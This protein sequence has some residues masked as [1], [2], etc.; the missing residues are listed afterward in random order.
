MK[1]PLALILALGFTLAA[2]QN[3][4]ALQELLL[5][6]RPDL[7]FA[8]VDPNYARA[9]DGWVRDTLAAKLGARGAVEIYTDATLWAEVAPDRADDAFDRAVSLL[10]GVSSS[11]DRDGCLALS[12]WRLGMSEEAESAAADAVRSGNQTMWSPLLRGARAMAEA[13]APFGIVLDDP[14]LSVRDRVN[15]LS[16]AYQAARALLESGIAS[17]TAAAK[18]A[19]ESLLPVLERRRLVEALAPAQAGSG[20]EATLVLGRTQLGQWLEDSR[21][22][23]L[24]STGPTAIRARA[25]AAYLSGLS[26]R[27]GDSSELSFVVPS[28]RE[29]FAQA[30][31]PED[32]SALRVLASDLSKSA[33]KERVWRLVALLRLANNDPTGA[34]AAVEAVP[35]ELR[36]EGWRD[37]FAGLLYAQG[38]YDA[39]LGRVFARTT[40][41]DS[42]LM[43][44]IRSMVLTGRRA[45]AATAAQAAVAAYPESARIGLANA[46]LK[47]ATGQSDDVE[48]AYDLLER[49]VAIRPEDDGLRDD[50]TYNLAILCGLK[51]EVARAESLLSSVRDRTLADRVEKVR[52]ALKG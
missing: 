12:Y 9:F 14:N 32:R 11:T 31:A 26:V 36:D 17:C 18:I 39:V 2:A 20:G 19:P 5:P 44:H 52:A 8:R 23:A 15:A 40:A 22:I 35:N 49:L 21:K 7:S 43:M 29:R 41:S 48:R 51:G 13:K 28:D 27:Y 33:E 3:R 45:D 38:A 6:P 24:L 16:L 4:A 37:F 42:L 47:A 34:Q 50:A 30:V 46:I 25:A 1:A 10:L